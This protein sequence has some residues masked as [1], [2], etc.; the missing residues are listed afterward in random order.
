MLSD[1]FIKRHSRYRR[2]KRMSPEEMAKWLVDNDLYIP[3]PYTN[4]CPLPDCK[5]CKEHYKC[6]VNWLKEGT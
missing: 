5:N 2:I 4:D 1:I 3:I 6:V